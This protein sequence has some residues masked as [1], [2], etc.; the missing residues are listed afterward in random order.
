MERDYCHGIVSTEQQYPPTIHLQPRGDVWTGLHPCVKRI[1]IPSGH[2]FPKIGQGFQCGDFFRN[3]HNEKLIHGNLLLLRDLVS[4]G[5]QGLRQ[6]QCELGH[7]SDVFGNGKF[8]KLISDN[9]HE[10]LVFNYFS[11]IKDLHLIDKKFGTYSAFE[12]SL[13]RDKLEAMNFFRSTW[14][15]ISVDS[16]EKERFER[17]VN[18]IEE[19]PGLRRSPSWP[20]ATTFPAVA[21]PDIHA[22]LKPTETQKAAEVLQFELN[23]KSRPNWLT[24][25]RYIHMLQI[26]REGLKQLEPIDMIDVQSFL[27]VTCG[28]YEKS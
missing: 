12:D 15:L 17:Y 10:S 3:G 13:R 14:D 22:Y 8:E 21:R 26:C 11:V 23:Y 7:Y 16:I 27:F 25:Q 20:V 18:S 19:L 24:Y 6:L 5:K 9:N 2:P 4:V 28:G 1:K